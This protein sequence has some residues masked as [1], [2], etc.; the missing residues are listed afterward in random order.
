MNRLLTLNLISFLDFYF[1]FMFIAGTWRRWG[2]Y[3][4]V[5]KLVLAGPGRWPN[6]LKL[7]SEYRTIFWTWSTVSPALM[8]LGIWLLQVIVS[9]G[10]LPQASTVNGLT[11]GSLLDHWPALI[12]IVPLGL[13]MFGFDLYGLY[14]VGQI[15]RAAL[16]KYFDQAE[17][18]LRS[19]T[20]H[21]VRVVTFGRINP[22]RMVA[23]EVEKALLAVSDML[24][25]NLWWVNLQ[26]GLRFAF[27]LALW[28]TWAF[29][30]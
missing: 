2:Q 19:R 10:C 13:A 24:N 3:H 27:A 21:V 9:R 29:T 14:V 17:F 26:M 11:I 4:S 15:D 30:H 5:A 25:F 8:A 20:A 16:E 22:R 18:W 1:A 7:V 23:A 12:V 28:L 6:L